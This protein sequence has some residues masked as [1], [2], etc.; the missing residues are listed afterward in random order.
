M[1]SS[2]RKIR[3]PSSSGRTI[4]FTSISFS[5]LAKARVLARSLKRFHRDWEFVICISDRPPPGFTFDVEEEPFDRV[6]WAHELRIADVDAWLFKHDVVELCTAVKGPLLLSLLEE[7]PDA[8]VYLD[9]DIA[10]F[11]SLD[12]VLQELERSSIVLTPH[13]VDP[14][15]DRMAIFDNEVSSLRHGTYN[16]GFLAVRADDVAFD[17]AR[18]FDARLRSFC[19]AELDRGIFVDQKWCDLVPAF[20]DRVGILRDPGC[21]AASWN[22]SQRH[23]K[24]DES[25]SITVNGSPLSFFHFT[26]LGPIGDVMTQRYSGGNHAVQEVWR[27]YKHAVEREE[28]AG[29]PEDWWYYG[30]YENGDPID[31][32]VRV[33]YRWRE[34]LQAAFLHPFAVGEGSFHEWLTQQESL[35]DDHAG[36]TESIVGG[37]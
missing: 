20:F 22:L 18:W 26:K 4:C 36:T 21:N 28:T 13:Q 11:G 16:L 7:G 12:V 17:F 32:S 37:V 19:Y 24:I 5:Y 23:L 25:G 14:D 2:A 27:W 6:V 9:P 35:G 10:V 8:I 34:D 33:L 31:Y 15:T 1:S 29:I 3:R 30:R